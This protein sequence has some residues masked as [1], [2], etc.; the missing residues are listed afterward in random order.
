MQPRTGQFAD[1]AALAQHIG[2]V[3]TTLGQR[4]VLLGRQDGDALRVRDLA[5]QGRDLAP[6]ERRQ[7]EGRLVEQEYLGPRQEGAADRQHL[8]LTAAEKTR[9]DATLVTKHRE[10]VQDG[11]DCHSGPGRGVAT[12]AT[13]LRRAVGFR[14]R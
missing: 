4:D 8:L 12:A 3:G 10:T 1:D 7:A 6:D 11:V 9:M 14:G 5:Q 2:P 13:R